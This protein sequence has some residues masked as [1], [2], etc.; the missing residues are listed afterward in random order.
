MKVVQ[1]LRLRL[2][3]WFA[4]FMG[5]AL[6]IPSLGAT[7]S[8]FAERTDATPATINM[9][10]FGK[11]LP[12][13]VADAKGF[14][15]KHNLKVNYLQVASST[16][17]FQALRDGQYDVIQ[18]SPDNVANY[19]LNANNPLGTIV[20]S[21]G[22]LGLDYGLNLRL[23]A[24]PGITSVE[25]LRGKTVSVDALNSGFA[26]VL[27]KILQ[28]HGLQ[29][30]DYNVVSVGGVFQRY[31]DLLAGH[32][33]ATLLSSGFETRAANQGYVLLDPVST[34]ASPYIGTFAAARTTWLKQN[35]DVA[36]RFALAYYEALQW[37]FDPANREE[38]IQLLMAQPN[39]SRMLAEQLYAIHLQSGVGD[40]ADASIDHKAVYNILALR[41]EFNGFENQQ[42]LHRLAGPEG[43]LYDLSYYRKALRDYHRGF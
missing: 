39:T 12:L 21:Q 24:Q 2:N 13:I 14:Y 36:V 15:A 1:P 26:Y 33:D 6:L 20:D 9:G 19:Q 42:N 35:S 31:N 16:Q 37:S 5:A 29:Q 22:F 23:V 10:I 28:Q 3:V 25:N 11:S 40:I 32:A 17:Q 41:A 8:A 30:G 38:S 34:I 27:Y 7:Q 43:G 4:M 18:T